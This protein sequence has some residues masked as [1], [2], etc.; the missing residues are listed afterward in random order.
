MTG[1]VVE[2]PLEIL[3]GFCVQFTDKIK[4][5]NGLVLAVYVPRLDA[6]IGRVSGRAPEDG[7]GCYGAG[8][9]ESLPDDAVRRHVKGNR[10]FLADQ[11][12]P[13]SAFTGQ[14]Q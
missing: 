5:I 10:R 9:G 14:P 1:V 12:D 4:F 3:N 7:T 6:K 13:D 8:C 2:L 11:H